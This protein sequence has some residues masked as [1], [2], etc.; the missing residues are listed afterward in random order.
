MMSL[1]AAGGF[2]VLGLI[3]GIL[4]VRWVGRLSHRNL[5]G[6]GKCALCGQHGFIVR[7]K[8]CGKGVAMCHYYGILYP[9]TPDFKLMVKRRST[10]VCTACIS[11][12]AREAVEGL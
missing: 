1:M 12:P 2:L 8:A 4:L 3:L 7:C 10:H 5:V 6:Q 11:G 9:D